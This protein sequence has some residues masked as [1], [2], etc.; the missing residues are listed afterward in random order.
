MKLHES[1]DH[2]ETIGRSDLEREL[3][4]SRSTASVMLQ[5]GSFPNAFRLDGR[6]W[7][8]PRS[9][10]EA[11]KAARRVKPTQVGGGA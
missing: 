9:D 3:N 6:A 4:I 8:I 11:F 1:T 2:S 7:R 10:V 5:R